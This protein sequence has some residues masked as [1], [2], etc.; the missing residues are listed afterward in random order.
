[1]QNILLTVIAMRSH[2]RLRTTER[3]AT[4]LRSTRTFSG[5]VESL[6][7]SRVKALI[8]MSQKRPYLLSHRFVLHACSLKNCKLM[9]LEFT[10]LSL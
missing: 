7:S 9:I 3:S 6:N 1:M 2:T 5:V 8:M 10:F 4:L